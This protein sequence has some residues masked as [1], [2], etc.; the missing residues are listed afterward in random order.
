MINV[1]QIS[2]TLARSGQETFIMNVYRAIDRSKF[3][4]DFLVFTESTDGFYAEAE[5][6]GAKI[7]RL[8]V[9]RRR[10]YRYIKALDSFFKKWASYYDVI[11]F[12][13]CSLTT[14][15]PLYYAKKY[16]IKTR[17]IHSHSSS[18]SKGLHNF[19]LHTLNKTFIGDLATDYLACS[20]LALD[21]FYSG[22]KV[23]SKAVVIK[24]GINLELFRFKYNIREETRKRLNLKDKYVVG[25]VGRL[26]KVK[27]HKFLI[28]VFYNLKKEKP[29]SVLLLIGTGELFTELK[30]KVNQLN[31]LDSVFFMGE[32]TDVAALMMAMDVFVFPS[33]FEGL[34]FTLIEA[35]AVGLPIFCSDTI[36]RTV[37]VTGQISFFSLDKSPKDWSKLILKNSCNRVVLDPGDLNKIITNKGYS[38]KSTANQ[39]ETIYSSRV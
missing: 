20:D 30:E 7:H 16:G 3:N 34:P 28:D 1:L 13:T 27:N 10:L 29:N 18:I 31:L 33:F 39:L 9:K 24:N 35:Q 26:S 8:P 12:H 23:Q 5:S 25:H 14:V 36:S 22:T 32:R 4:F 37:N 2:G 15:M 38:I 21:F 19:I 17:I 11:H 6:M